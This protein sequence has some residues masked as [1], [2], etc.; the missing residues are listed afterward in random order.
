MSLDASEPQRMTSG[1]SAMGARCAAACVL[2]RRANRGQPP[3][4]GIT[5]VITS[6][7]MADS[8]AD[9]LPSTITRRITDPRLLTNRGAERR[10]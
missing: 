1:A 2:G 4:D 6:S 8:A 9:L 5:M 7:V 3:L 10:H